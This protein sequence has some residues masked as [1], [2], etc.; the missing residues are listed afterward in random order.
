MIVFP[1]NTRCF[2]SAILFSHSCSGIAVARAPTASVWKDRSN[3]DV[4][5]S[6]EIS[7]DYIY[8]QVWKLV[9]RTAA[10]KSLL[11]AFFMGIVQSE[12]RTRANL[13]SALYFA[14]QMFI[15][16][17]I[18]FQWHLKIPFFFF[19][20]WKKKVRLFYFNVKII[21]SGSYYVNV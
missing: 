13:F 17:C 5:K 10:I 18:C 14:V 6:V 8:P 2:L 9:C 19:V 12:R 4:S 1:R 21:I 3:V 11:T 16:S 15:E 7:V 20:M